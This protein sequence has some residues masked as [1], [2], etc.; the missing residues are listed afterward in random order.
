MRP[1]EM[2]LRISGSRGSAVKE[3]ELR[4]FWLWTVQMIE[5]FSLTVSWKMTQG[6][7]NL[8]SMSE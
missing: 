1:E 4:L 5:E 2:S 7:V 6:S 8:I 3:M